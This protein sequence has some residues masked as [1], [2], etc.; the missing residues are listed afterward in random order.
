MSF[1]YLSS[2]YLAR[3]CGSAAQ[4]LRGLTVGPARGPGRLAN[5]Y[6]GCERK[7]AIGTS[8]RDAVQSRGRPIRS[9]TATLTVTACTA[10]GRKMSRLPLTR[11]RQNRRSRPVDD[12]LRPGRSRPRGPLHSVR[13]SMRRS[14]RSWGVDRLSMSGCSPRTG[15]TKAASRE[16]LL[17]RAWQGHR[18]AY[19]A[20]SVSRCIPV[21]AG[22]EAKDLARRTWPVPARSRRRQLT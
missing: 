7:F 9:Q 21:S 1:F 11:S 5:T 10:T 8:I 19:R 20:S 2:Q 13:R 12:T 14:R 22:R 4:A 3:D 6:R 15:S 18:A 17:A 16:T